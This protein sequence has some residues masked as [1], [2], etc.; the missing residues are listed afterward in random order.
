MRCYRA[1]KNEVL[2]ST[3]NPKNEVL[4]ST[5]LLQRIHNGI[6]R[7]RCYRALI[8]Y[9]GRN[10]SMEML[11]GTQFPCSSLTRSINIALSKKRSRIIHIHENMESI[12]RNHVK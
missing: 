6:L 10:H 3:Q 12:N 11:Q 8:A 2:Q 9:D 5:Q 4:Q 1:L 7:M